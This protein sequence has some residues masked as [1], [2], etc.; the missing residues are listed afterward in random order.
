MFRKLNNKSIFKKLKK[1]D[2]NNNNNEINNYVEINIDLDDGFHL[3]DVGYLCLC[4]HC[5]APPPSPPPLDLPPPSPQWSLWTRI[6]QLCHFLPVC[7]RSKR[8]RY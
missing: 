7:Y 5:M 1:K 6:L 2:N 8:K 4:D 3:I